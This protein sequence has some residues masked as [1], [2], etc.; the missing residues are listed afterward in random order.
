[1]QLTAE[2]EVRAAVARR[3]L[4]Q[5]NPGKDVHYP[6][7]LSADGLGLIVTTWGMFVQ[8]GS[9]WHKH[10]DEL[11]DFEAQVVE[12][13][14]KAREGFTHYGKALRTYLVP[15]APGGIEEGSEEGLRI[16]APEVPIPTEGTFFG[17][18]REMTWHGAD[19][20]IDTEDGN[21]AVFKDARVVGH[22]GLALGDHRDKDGNVVMTVEEAPASH[23]GRTEGVNLAIPGDLVRES[24][25]K[26]M[27][28]PPWPGVGKTENPCTGEIRYTVPK[29]VYEELERF[30]VAARE[31]VSQGAE[32]RPWDELHKLGRGAGCKGSPLLAQLC[33]ALHTRSGIMGIV[34]EWLRSAPP[35]ARKARLEALRKDLVSW[36]LGQIRGE[37]YDHVCVD[38]LEEWTVD[39]VIY[40]LQSGLVLL[41]NAAG[42]FVV[43]KGEERKLRAEEGRIPQKLA[44]EVQ[45]HP[46]TL[47]ERGESSPLALGPTTVVV[48]KDEHKDEH[49]AGGFKFEVGKTYRHLNGEHMRIVGEVDTLL[50]GRT[51]VGESSEKDNLVPV[52][53]GSED[54]TQNWREVEHRDSYFIEEE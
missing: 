18:V 43:H 40:L 41:R 26:A 32:K 4:D 54:A 25:Y 36:E 24:L 19:L 6:L 13:L 30:F 50:Y 16:P 51:G 12:D 47:D 53:M 9:W 17:K 8:G 23:C 33:A 20:H 34:K 28:I 22:R 5:N 7:G 45:E 10:S 42:S 46:W 1:M 15:L 44:D 39:R 38:E 49:K 35:V 29:S 27:G 2:Q 52:D 14:E 3:V 11:N 48:I 31:G 21:R 37:S